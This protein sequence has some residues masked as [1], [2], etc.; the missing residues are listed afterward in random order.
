MYMFGYGKVVVA[1][2]GNRDAWKDICY[3]Q[4]PEEWVTHANQDH[5][6]KHQVLVSWQKTAVGK[7]LG[8]SLHWGFLGKDKSGRG[9]QFRI[10]EF[11]QF[12]WALVS[13]CLVPDPGV[14]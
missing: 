12:Q 3:T 2:E 14:T 7:G 4:A 5:R 6:G 8:Q 1:T 10:V 11:E 13:S 9:K